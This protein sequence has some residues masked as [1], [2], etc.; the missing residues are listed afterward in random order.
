MGV[1]AYI[2]YEYNK[3][4]IFLKRSVTIFIKVVK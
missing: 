3:L 2:N 4:G 1:N